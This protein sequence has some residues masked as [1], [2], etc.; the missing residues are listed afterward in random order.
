MALTI[1]PSHGEPGWQRAT[2]TRRTAYVVGF[3]RSLSRL[4]R[5]FGSFIAVLFKRSDGV[6][7]GPSGHGGW[8]FAGKT[9][10]AFLAETGLFSTPGPR[11][12]SIPAPLSFLDVL[13]D[14]LT[15]AL[16]PDGSPFALAD[17]VILTPTRRAA[18]GLMDAFAARLGGAA[19]LPT[20]RPLADLED[21]PDVWGADPIGLAIPPAIPTM[22]RRMELAALIRA[23]DASAGGVDDP[24]RALALA[25]EL[26]ALLDG[27]AAAGEVDWAR[28]PTL[29]EDERLAAHWR[30][31]AAF[32][33]IIAQYWPQ[34]LAADGLSDPA[35]RRN[36]VLRALAAEWGKH[37]P[38]TPVVI[39]GS[40]GSLPATR[41][42]MRVTAD[43]PLGAVVLPGLD[44]GLDDAAWEAIGPQHPQATL[45][46]TLSAFGLSRHKVRS[47]GPALEPSQAAR[48]V[49]LREALA[50][51]DATAD[52]L[53]RL[54]RAG[55]PAVLE[56]GA[57]G[58]TL[59]EAA[60]ETDEAAA[61]AIALI[62]ATQEPGGTAAL[63][64][65]SA[66]LARRVAA[67]LS[68]LGE[69]PALSL[70]RPLADSPVGELLLALLALFADDGDPAALATV[71][72]HALRSGPSP[73]AAA[74]LEHKYLR[75]PRRWRDLAG[76]IALGD[77]DNV[78]RPIQ[79]AL[80]AALV[81]EEPA[82]VSAAANRLC[83]AAESLAEETLWSGAAG[84][85]AA[86]LLREAIEAGEALGPMSKAQALRT[87]R[88]LI[89][90]TEAPPEASGEGAIAIVG[91]L[92][93]RLQRRDLIV[94]GGLNEGGWPEPP[95]EGAFL[96]RTM[97]ASLGLV[98][99]DQRV[100]LSA[101]DFAQLASAPRV[102]LTRAKREGGAPAVASRW[103]WR[104]TT[105]MRGAGAE[106][107]LDPTPEQD[108]ARWAAALN[109]PS[110][111]S[112]VKP[113]AP[114]QSNPDDLTRLSVTEIDTLIRDPYAVYARRVLGL[115]ALRPI[116]A[117]A[118]PAERGSAAHRAVERFEGLPTNARSE[119]QLL[120]LL[121]EELEGIGFRPGRLAAD[122]ARLEQAAKAYAAW[123]RAQAALGGSIFLE[124]PG[125]MTLHDLGL[126]ITARA[127]RIDLFQDGAQ[128]TDVKTGV[129]PTMD[130]MSQ[131]FSPQ[132]LLEAA[133]LA[134]GGFE[135]AP[136]SIARD[137]VFWRLSG[138]KA[139]PVSVRIK[140]QSLMDAVTDSV[141]SLRALA[142][143]YRSGQK[144]FRSKPRAFFAKPYADYDHLA[145]RAEWTAE[146]EE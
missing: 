58:L 125:R 129:P 50:P 117:E 19:L 132:L 121:V 3:G 123:S 82:F 51:A 133:I 105:L 86:R 146:G 69:P 21:D 106:A 72:K 40:T 95:A 2:A 57:V 46:E 35:A 83:A 66:A 115:K 97:R 16:P 79:A 43:L 92:E 75:G 20:M 12:F 111:P 27:A 44:A 23:R 45:K 55:G 1:N 41:E 120:A 139:E 70:G 136:A 53:G 73:A 63:V 32:L 78:L 36:A 30:Q 71:V 87:L 38:Q 130:Q 104:L 90:R 14:A 94:L 142:A 10:G 64:T 81:L 9:G 85:A 49:L 108:Y 61:I 26:C 62:D 101:H 33:S 93:A 140:D 6:E 17:A 126:T 138:A 67:K 102:I 134:E 89:L 99:P 7:S 98:S 60:T 65:P 113:P 77:Q 59:I 28:L 54:D 4:S 91:P 56:S 116:G 114:R 34:R 47:L 96:N 76:L 119:E 145:R 131:N 13:A 8:V 141:T 11:V 25:D 122:A 52:W 135:G 103:V 18:R 107:R 144:P 127:D 100:G 88:L 24:V 80:A 74:A 124:V 37:K 143:A 39:A 109:A 15:E 128:I 5:A 68:G 29:V 112:P 31:S 48:A 84:E 42:L 137:L 118:G 110:T 22:Q